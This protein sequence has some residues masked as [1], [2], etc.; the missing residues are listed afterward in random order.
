M[1]TF[2]H[3]IQSPEFVEVFSQ[4]TQ[5]VADLCAGLAKEAG[6]DTKPLDVP[7]SLMLIVSEI[8]EGMEGHRKGLMDDKLPH[9]T[10]LSV[11]L[12]DA[13]IRIFHLAGRL[14]VPIGEILVEK[15]VFNSIR[16][17]HKPAHRAAEGGKKY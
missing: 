8:S 17:D 5:V 16:A 7:C 9:H 1:T 4:T 13:V 11:E 2:T 12:A 6:W 3:E 15:L 14:G 10:M